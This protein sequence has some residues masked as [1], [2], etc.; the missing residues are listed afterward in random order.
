M[1]EKIK[2]LLIVLL[3]LLMVV[4]LAINLSLGLEERD[5]RGIGTRLGLRMDQSTSILPVSEPAVLPAKLAIR[6]PNGL[7]LADGSEMTALLGTV[8]P[9][10]TEA[11]GSVGKISPISQREFLDYLGGEHIA[12]AF[13]F[14]VPFYLLQH[15]WTGETGFSSDQAASTLAVVSYG[16]EVAVIFC[17]DDTGKYYLAETAAG[18]E[19]FLSQCQAAPAGNAF[20]AFERDGFHM[21]RAHEPVWNEAVYYPT[22]TVTVPDF[23]AEGAISEGLLYA[24]DVNPFLAE[25]YKESDGDIVYI[26]GYNALQFSKGGRITYSVTGDGGIDLGLDG[27]Y[28]E[29]ERIAQAAR[30][31]CDVLEQVC[32]AA[33]CDGGFSVADITTREGSMV[34]SCERFLG[35][36]FITETDGYSAVVTLQDGRITAIR[37]TL[38]TATEGPGAMLLPIQ[39]ATSLLDGEDNSFFIRYTASEE[40]YNPGLYSTKGGMRHGME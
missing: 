26:E 35:G 20:Y 14:P 11:L 16:E 25:V 32:A 37:I 21:L 36:G 7:H 39:L 23:S 29:K 9:I 34:I 28:S 3:G 30:R 18:Y 15:W 12:F 2:N 27:L 33:G 38:S 13:T 22:Y 24:F 31:V 8:S 6:G 40:A 17:D 10:L 1:R 19:R 5:L 4:Q